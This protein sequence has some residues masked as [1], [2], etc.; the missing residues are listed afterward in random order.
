MRVIC[1]VTRILLASEIF[2]PAR[3]E[4]LNSMSCLPYRAGAGAE[5]LARGCPF[6]QR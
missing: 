2:R 3:P 1:M 5:R 6:A 4:S